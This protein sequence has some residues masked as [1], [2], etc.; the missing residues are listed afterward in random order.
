VTLAGAL[1][2]NASQDLTKCLTDL[3]KK[4]AKSGSLALYKV[5]LRKWKVER[6]EFRQLFFC[7]LGQSPKELFRNG[8]AAT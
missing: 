3:D 2:F 6:A 5:R 7:L 1:V 4:V 8:A